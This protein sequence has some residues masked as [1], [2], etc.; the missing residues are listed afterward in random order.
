[1]S[2]IAELWSLPWHELQRSLAAGFGEN[3]AGQ[4]GGSGSY[5]IKHVKTPNVISPVGTWLVRARAA[6]GRSIS[7]PQNNCRIIVR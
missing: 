3:A 5:A 7:R 1:M 2:D 6:P 4:A